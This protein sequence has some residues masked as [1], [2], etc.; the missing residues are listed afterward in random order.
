MWLWEE[1]VFILFK[2][3]LLD[4]CVSMCMFVYGYSYMGVPM[5]A[6]DDLR[7]SR[8]GITNS[9]EPPTWVL[10]AKLG[11]SARIASTFNH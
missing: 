5:E 3:I 10:R 1:F 9:Y 7:F 8:V 4:L 6:K 11:S 2:R